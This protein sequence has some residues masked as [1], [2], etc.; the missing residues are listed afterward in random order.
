MGIH[1][2]G[3]V[4]SYLSGF[5]RVALVAALVLLQFGVIVWLSLWL[6]GYTVYI[7]AILEIVSIIFIIGLVNASKSQSYKIS[8]ICIILL[9]PLTGHIMYALWGNSEIK[10]KIEKKTL[11]KI[12]HG[13]TFLEYDEKAVEEFTKKY[14]TKSRMVRFLESQNFPLFQNNEVTYY[15]M[16]EDTFEAI[17]ADIKEAKKFIFINFFIVGEGVLWDKMHELLKS[18][19]KEGVDVYFMYDE[20]GATLRTSKY[21]K[22]NL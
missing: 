17:F 9:L 6:S 22:R 15:P 4:K 14:P 16:G 20:F 13:N 21:F 7:Y 3:M 19:I 18:K 12:R 5:L 10:N 1:E 8:W 11:Y 2:K